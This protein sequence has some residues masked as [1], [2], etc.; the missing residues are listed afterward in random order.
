MSVIV[1]HNVI[2]FLIKDLQYYKISVNGKSIKYLC[3]I[4]TF[5]IFNSFTFFGGI[6][7]QCVT[8]DIYDFRLV[9]HFCFS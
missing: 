2:N 9:S 1:I 6:T 8:Y 7:K 3:D 5:E 4:Y